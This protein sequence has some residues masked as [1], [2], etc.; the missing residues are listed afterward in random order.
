MNFLKK[1]KTLEIEENSKVS[2]QFECTI[3]DAVFTLKENLNKHI[4]SFHDESKSKEPLK[5][6]ICYKTGTSIQEMKNHADLMHEGRT[7]LNVEVSLCKVCSE[8]FITKDILKEHL[9]S[10]HGENVQ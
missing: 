9:E 6:K 7:S 5:C 2:E 3:C 8:V 1:A 10:A 4:E